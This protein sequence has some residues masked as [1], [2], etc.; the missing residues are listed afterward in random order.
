[1]ESGRHISE[2]HLNTCLEIV[3]FSLM[4]QHKIPFQQVILRLVLGQQWR[5]KTFG[6]FGPSLVRTPA[7][8]V[9]QRRVDLVGYPACLEP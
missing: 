2:S 8:N 3:C 5:L 7:A 1:M 9:S 4:L 6:K